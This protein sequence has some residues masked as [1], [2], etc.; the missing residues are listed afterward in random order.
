LKIYVIT[1]CRN[2]QTA[3]RSTVQSVNKLRAEDVYF[4]IVDGNSHDGTKDFLD[5]A[6]NLVDQWISEPDG[7]IYDAMNKAIDRLPQ[8]DGHVLFLGAGDR[9][10]E[11]PTREQREAGSV[12]FG[13]VQIGGRSFRSSIGWKLKAGNTVHHQGLFYP[14]TIFA[15][16]HFDT[17]YK[18]YGDLDLNQR[19]FQAKVSFKPLHKTIALAEPGGVSW[20]A[21]QS[22]MI[23]ISRKNFGLFWGCAAHAWSVYRAVR[24]R[25]SGS[26]W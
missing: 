3:L 15:N 8:E 25:I 10:L 20:G 9:L 14:R 2:A 16:W 7:G 13:N 22:E 4:S 17:H 6:G 19:L 26:Y 18:I 11:L 12:L 1:V 5:A 24:A 23:Q 21:S